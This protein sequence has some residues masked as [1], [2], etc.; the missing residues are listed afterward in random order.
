MRHAMVK[1]AIFAVGGVAVGATATYFVVKSKFKKLADEEISSLRQHYKMKEQELLMDK[2]DELEQ[3]KQAHGLINHEDPKEAFEIYKARL[4]EMEYMQREA[5]EGAVEAIE[6]IAEDPKERISYD[7]ISKNK[8]F[9]DV[10][11]TVASVTSSEELRVVDEVA[12]NAETEDETFRKNVFEASIRA[13]VIN[14]QTDERSAPYIISVEEFQEE[15]DELEKTTLSY[16]DDGT[17]ADERNMPIPDANPII[18]DE[19]L[20]KFGE[21]SQDENIVYVRNEKL[22]TDFEVVREEGSYADSFL[23]AK[24]WE[25]EDLNSWKTKNKNKRMREDGE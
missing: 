7:K 17:L 14:G 5:E 1:P 23:K 25:D 19:N 3:I 18:G 10:V 13:D 16:Y 24:D 8:N 11:R 6:K 22:S 2:E 21:L 20:E 4:D 12:D 15:S 9:E